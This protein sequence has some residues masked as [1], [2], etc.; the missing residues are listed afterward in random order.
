MNGYTL[1]DV[2]HAVADLTDMSY[3]EE[4]WAEFRYRLLNNEAV[5]TPLGF[6]MM[7]EDQWSEVVDSYGDFPDGG[8][9]IVFSVDNA[10]GTR[11][12]KKT[13]Y[14]SSFDGVEFDGALIEVRPGL[15]IEWKVVE[16]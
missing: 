10:V 12:F 2:E 11:Y 5:K 4:A 14:R 3:M 16:Q 7:Q 8:V 13:G 6:A 9:W 1:D 15:R